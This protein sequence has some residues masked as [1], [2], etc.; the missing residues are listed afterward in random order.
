MVTVGNGLSHCACSYGARFGEGWGTSPEQLNAA[1]C[2]TMTLN[3]KLGAAG[4]VPESLH[5]TMRFSLKACIED[6]YRSVSLEPSLRIRALSCPSG[7]GTLQR[8]T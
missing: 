2:Y 4:H 7:F 1:V 3:A 8:G 5:M 6:G